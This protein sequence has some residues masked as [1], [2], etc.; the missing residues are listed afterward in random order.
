MY[1]P[2]Y[3]PRPQAQQSSMQAER[4]ELAMQHQELEARELEAERRTRALNLIAVRD[5]ETNSAAPC[6]RSSQ[7]HTSQEQAPI[8]PKRASSKVPSQRSLPLNC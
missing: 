6:V 7:T 1:M 8:K 5:A 3:L 2:S 4:K